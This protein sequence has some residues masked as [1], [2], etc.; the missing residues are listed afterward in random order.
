MLDKPVPSTI[1]KSVIL[2]LLIISVAI[3]LVVAI[4][5]IIT[6][7]NNVDFL[8]FCGCGGCGGD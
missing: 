6:D 4:A 7:M 1:T 5:K 3:G 8:R 2:K